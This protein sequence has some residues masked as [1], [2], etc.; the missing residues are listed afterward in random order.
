MSC[1]QK[2]TNYAPTIATNQI[3][4]SARGEKMENP[5]EFQLLQKQNSNF[6]TQHSHNLRP[7]IKQNLCVCFGLHRNQ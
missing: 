4:A 5:I 7:N 3:D 6:R 2:G 1:K